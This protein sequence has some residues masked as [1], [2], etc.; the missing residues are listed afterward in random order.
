MAL[1]NAFK[2]PGL[3]RYLSQSLG[4]DIQRVESFRGLDGPE[5]INAPSFKENILSFGVCYG[6]VLQGLGKG[7]LKTNLLPRQIVHDRLIR[8]KK[9]WAVAAAALLMLASSLAFAVYSADW[10]TVSPQEWK[11]GGDRSPPVTAHSTRLLADTEKIKTEYLGIKQIGD[12]LVSNIEGRA[13][14]L[15]LLWR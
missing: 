8:Q 15:E 2:L 3:R 11:Q 6:L 5:V 14:W 4:F 10:G 7:G 12:H 9:P 1:G 13:W